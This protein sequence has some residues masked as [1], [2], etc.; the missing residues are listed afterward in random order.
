[1]TS[2]LDDVAAL[3]RA[4][5]IHLAQQRLH[6]SRRDYIAGIQ[7]IEGT[8][9][10]RYIELVGKLPNMIEQGIGP[11]DQRDALL[12][13]AK[14][15]KD[16]QRYKSIPFRH[17]SPSSKGASGTP[18]GSQFAGVLSS[19]SASRLG[20][21]VFKQAQ[22]LKGRQRLSSRTHFDLAPKL[23]PH[24][25]AS[26]FEGMQ[27]VHKQYRSSSQSQ[28]M[29]FRTISEGNP[30]GWIHPGIVA[31]NLHVE[32]ESHINDALGRI[33]STAVTK[34]LRG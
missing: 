21:S 20:S 10:E 25:R 24:H 28:F 9:D 12:T 3:S 34:A 1:M 33:V 23:K 14:I 18:M 26:P 19:G 17:G 13:N 5:W 32:V 22:A 30:E 2:V 16:G 27:K 11:F 8:G 4:R 6:S 31:R 7:A 15:N 29:S